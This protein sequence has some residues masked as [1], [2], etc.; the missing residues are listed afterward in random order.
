MIR[1]S[2]RRCIFDKKPCGEGLRV[3]GSGTT[4]MAFMPEQL[5]AS[6]PNSGNRRAGDRSKE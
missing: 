6:I 3:S 5:G 2:W 4:A 1:W